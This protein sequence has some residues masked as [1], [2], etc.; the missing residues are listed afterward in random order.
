MKAGVDVKNMNLE[1][2][3]AV[4]EFTEAKWADKFFR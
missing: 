1:A 4:I 2:G 3:T